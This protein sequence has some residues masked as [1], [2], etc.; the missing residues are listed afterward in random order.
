MLASLLGE[1][2]SLALAT[3]QYELTMA[4]AYWKNGL[5]ERE[6]EFH[7]LFRTPPFGGGFVVLAGLGSLIDWLRAFRFSAGD[8]AYLATLRDRVGGPLFEAPF[9]AY[10]G[11]LRFGCDVFAV[12]EGTLVFPGEPLVRVRGPIL[13]AQL[14][15]TAV[16]NLINFE[17]LIATKAARV[18][19]AAR[20]DPVIDFGYRRAQGMDGALSASR[21]AYL[22]GCAGTSNVLAGKLLGIPVLGTHAH[23]WVMAFEDERESFEAYAR[24][25]PG[26]C[27]LLVDTYG[28][29]AGVKN[30]IAVGKRLAAEGHRLAGIRL[31]SGDLAWLS[32]RARAM[33]DEAGLTQAVVMA[34]SDLDEYV[35]QSLK[36]QHARIGA[37]GVGTK[38]VTGWGEPALGGVYK[39]CAIRA[40][41][42]GPWLNR[43]KLSEQKVKI[44]LPGRLQVYRCSDPGGKF[45]ADA[46]AE[47]DEPPADIARIIDPNDNTH[48]KALEGLAR[49]PLLVPVFERGRLV[50]DQPGLEAIRTRVRDQL[51][52]L[53]D[54]HKR[55]EN[56]HV[57]P[58]GLSP[59]LNALRDRMI[60][61]A[62]A[63]VAAAQ[64]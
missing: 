11:A 53:D 3:D 26:N 44:S 25:M 38:L 41:A 4:A 52:R 47:L 14:L 37:W 54:G 27:V 24:A 30:A 55:F 64:G 62:R 63:R 5:A 46:I 17:S 6:A 56:P 57:Y 10:L 21:S 50:Y 51:G 59:R 18:C 35:I 58:V 34:S 16:L 42:G 32:I 31:D 33:L 1:D 20:G 19:L 15:E 39:L 48:V 9:L 23:S 36:A 2:P 61:E 60:I 22:G 8:L 40:P 13:Q 45:A 43:L 29:L 28:T 12:P 49:E 7:M